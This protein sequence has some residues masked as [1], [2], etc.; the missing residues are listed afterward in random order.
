MS[1]IWVLALGCLP[2]SILSHKQTIQDSV[3]YSM[4]KLYIH[5][6]FRVDVVDPR[7]AWY[8]LFGTQVHEHNGLN[9]TFKSNCPKEY[10]YII[11]TAQ[12]AL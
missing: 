4:H 3:Q 10:I 1:I 7:K 5:C 11:K 12:T 2:T 8:K 6:E 9:L